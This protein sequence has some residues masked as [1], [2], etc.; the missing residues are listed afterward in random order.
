M[1]ILTQGMHANGQ[2][3]ASP[4][5][6]VHVL[7]ELKWLEGTVDQNSDFI[8]CNKITIADIQL[9]AILDFFITFDGVG[10]P[11]F[12]GCFDG[13]PWLTAWYERMGKR[14]AASAS[15]PAADG[16]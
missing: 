3:D 4:G 14:P 9:Y 2:P 10:E 5:R 16:K 15:M 13:L 11:C 12:K 8:C 1:V 6:K 7:N